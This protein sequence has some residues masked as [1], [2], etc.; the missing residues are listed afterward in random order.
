MR[1]AGLEEAQARIKV[2]GRTSNNLRYS[3]YTTLMAESEELKILLMKV[4]EESE[5]FQSL[6]HVYSF[7]TPWTICR[8]LLSMQFP[9]LEYWSGL[10]FPSPGD[11][12]DPG[13][14]PTYPSLTDGFSTTEPPGKPWDYP[15]L[16][17]IN[18]DNLSISKALI[19]DIC[20][21]I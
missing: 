13:I 6:S 14:E 3:D 10:L 11:L 19:Y 7:V 12:P 5:K 20:F 9:R 2:S 17:Q 15:G 4:K 21:A 16:V 18:Q 1:H 8:A